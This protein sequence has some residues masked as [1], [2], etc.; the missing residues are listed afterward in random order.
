[1]LLNPYQTLLEVLPGSR[2]LRDASALG[3]VG[4]CIDDPK[5]AGRAWQITNLYAP[6]ERRHLG[7]IRAKLLDQKGFVTFCNQRDLE[8]LLG[9][10]KPGQ[11]C[12][13]T[14]QDYPELDSQEFYGLCADEEDL[15]DD[16]FERE[17]VLRGEQ[18]GVLPYGLELTRRIHTSSGIDAEELNTMLWDCDPDTG[19]GP[20]VRLETVHN[21]WASVERTK[22]RWDRIQ[23][24]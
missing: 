12:I 2:M 24:S 11:L 4:V 15:Q 10:A 14:D 13:W 22:V 16:L 1:M 20:D 18:P 9:L 7:G 21:R 5:R 8:L 19:W 23:M 6:I 17:L 3:L